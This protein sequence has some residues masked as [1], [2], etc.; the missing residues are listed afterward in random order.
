LPDQVVHLLDLLILT[1]QHSTWVDFSALQAQPTTFGDGD[2]SVME[3][4]FNR[5]QALI[6]AL[7]LDLFGYNL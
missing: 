3:G 2:D 4:I 1:C 5:R 7:C 6:G